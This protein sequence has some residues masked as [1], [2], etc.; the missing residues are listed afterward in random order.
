MIISA[1]WQMA[2]SRLC[3]YIK[4]LSEIH[5]LFVEV[6]IAAGLSIRALR[7]VPVTCSVLDDVKSWVGRRGVLAP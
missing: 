2:D 4:Q 1:H 6:H 5:S 7:A 3:T